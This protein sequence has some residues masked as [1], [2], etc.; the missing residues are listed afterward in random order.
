[1]LS[2]RDALTADQRAERAVTIAERVD[3]LLGEK[4]PHVVAMYAAKG[5]E[6]STRA[7][8]VA[9]R[10]RGMRVVYPRVV[11][12]E[13]RLVFCEVTPD[14]LVVGRFSLAEPPLDAP[15]VELGE[16][17]AFLVPGLAFDRRNGARLG[18]GRGHYD[19]TLSVV[20]AALR[21][22]LAFDIQM[23]DG[24]AHE[25]HDVAMNLI[26]TEVATYVVS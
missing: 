4:R 16:I 9:A 20:P 3:G 22:G 15:Q 10:A 8:D 12:A 11:T 25:P 14:E 21:I 24:I 17:G 13:L 19:A 18:W 23:V 7:I 1:M 6:V 2:R 5:S 26:V